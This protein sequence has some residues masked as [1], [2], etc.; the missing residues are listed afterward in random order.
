[1]KEIKLKANAKINLFLDV[2]DR[3]PDGYHNIETIFQS[4]N[5]HDTLIFREAESIGIKCDN[6]DIPLDS[7]NLVYKSA[8]LLLNESGRNLGAEIDII[9]RILSAEVWLVEAQTHLQH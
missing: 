8:E 1:M 5:L 9:K 3:R 7:S 2:L 6:P 4:I